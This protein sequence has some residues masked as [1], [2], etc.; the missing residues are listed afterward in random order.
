MVVQNLHN[1]FHFL[2]YLKVKPTGLPS[3]LVYVEMDVIEEKGRG[4]GRNGDIDFDG[5]QIQ[6]GN[7]VEGIQDDLERG[8][9]EEVQHL[10]NEEMDLKTEPPIEK[11]DVEGEIIE[12][13]VGV[14]P[15]IKTGDKI[16]RF[17]ADSIT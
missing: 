11:I 12:G 9:S 1:Q 15:K 17:M 13:I 10:S 14:I 7:E 5:G 6:G 4:D 16:F 8:N 2:V 3:L